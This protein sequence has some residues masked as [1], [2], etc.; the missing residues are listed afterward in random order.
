MCLRLFCGSEVALPL[1]PWTEE[2]DPP[3]AIEPLRPEEE[4]VRKNLSQSN[5]YRLESY[6]GCF[7]EFGP[8]S[9]GF[10]SR[11][12]AKIWPERPEAAERRRK[13]LEALAQV[14]EEPAR[15]GRP[16][17]WSCWHGEEDAAPKVNHERQL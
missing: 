6:G 13:T 5:I 16:M 17:L 12:L 14:L 15:H 3:L 1:R 4:L 7:C 10:L 2:S 8:K 11:F 9:K